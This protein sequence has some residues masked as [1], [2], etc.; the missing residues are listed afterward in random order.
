M[1]NNYIII[2][3]SEDEEVAVWAEEPPKPG[4]YYKCYRFEDI[5]NS[6]EWEQKEAPQAVGTAESLEVLMREIDGKK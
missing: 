5:V 1:K 2:Q 4:T 3:L 6:E